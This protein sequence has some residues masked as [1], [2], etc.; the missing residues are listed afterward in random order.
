MKTNKNVVRKKEYH[1][2]EFLAGIPTLD[3]PRGGNPR[4][5]QAVFFSGM[6]KNWIKTQGFTLIELLVIVLI[7]GILAAVA[8]PQYQKAVKK[9]QGREVIVAIKALDKALVVYALQHGDICDGDAGHC[10]QSVLDIELPSVKYFTQTGI[11]IDEYAPETSTVF[12]SVAG[13]AK[14]T[15]TWDRTT[16]Q[17]VSS[18]CTGNDCSSYFGGTCITETVKMCYGSPARPED[19]DHCPQG[20]KSEGLF[21]SCELD[22]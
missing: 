1:S 13:D 9:A 18:T 3:I 20:Q 6:T 7:I 4:P 15:A 22:I 16:G 21:T 17:R 10:H 12:Q 5:L 8:L 19:W 14:L 11:G 2:R